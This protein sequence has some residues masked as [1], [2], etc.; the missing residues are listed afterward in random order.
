MITEI[1]KQK[2]LDVIFLQEIH[3]DNVIEIEWGLGWTGQCMFSHGTNCC[4]GVGILFS[5]TLD[6]QILASTECINGRILHVKAEI[7]GVVIHFTN[8]YASNYGPERK[9][10]FKMLEGKLSVIDCS[11]CIIL[12]G[13]WNCCVDYTLDRT[14][15]EAH[16][17]SSNFLSH[18]LTK[19]DLIDVWR[20]NNPMSRQYTWVRI[21]EGRCHAARLDR[22]YLSGSY[23]TRVVNCDIVSVGLTD[24]HMILMELVLAFTGTQ[25]SFWHFNT[26][27]LRDFTFCENFKWFKAFWR[28]KKHE[29]QSLIGWWEV[30]K[31]QIRNFC[32]QCTYKSTDNLRR[33]IWQ[34]EQEITD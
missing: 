16:F 24:H 8:V 13:D 22:F 33:L 34:L 26:K 31:A 5:P 30:G 23:S 32:Q 2:T 10:Q 9:H 3:S 14:G 18:V 12:G 11:E 20:R 25:K 29:F 1:I 21:A 17:E 7:Q 4:A 19:M 6:I 28:S 27:L 15:E